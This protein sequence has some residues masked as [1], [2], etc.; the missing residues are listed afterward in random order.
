MCL[1]ACTRLRKL[2]HNCLLFLI[3]ALIGTLAAAV[4]AVHVKAWHC[5][6]AL[7]VTQLLFC[8]GSVYLK[9][10]LLSLGALGAREFHP[11]VYAFIR[12]AVA[13]PVMCVIAYAQSGEPLAAEYLHTMHGSSA[14]SKSPEL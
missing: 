5:Q 9:S 2:L 4:I 6:V 10:S 11:I 1:C 8:I 14:G 13:G 3:M 12:E 7:A